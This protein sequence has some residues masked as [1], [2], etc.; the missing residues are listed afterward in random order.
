MNKKT[1]TTL[2]TILS[3][4][5]N[6]LF[7]LI[8]IALLII[9]ATLILNK[10]IKCTNGQVYMIVYMFCFLGGMVLN[11]FIFGKVS[12]WVIEKFDLASKLD[13][14]MLGKTLP[15]GKPNK[16]AYRAE[17]EKAEKP[18]TNMPD[19]VKEEDDGWGD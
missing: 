11:M 5:I 1:F 2:F 16:A 6:I 14:R 3:T 4:L 10:G 9:A 17:A 19:S 8:V 7:T 12:G 18:K 13:E 15:N